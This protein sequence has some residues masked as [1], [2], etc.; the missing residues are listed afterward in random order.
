MNNNGSFEA[1]F[2]SMFV[3][4]EVVI[5][6]VVRFEDLMLESLFMIKKLMMQFVCL[7]RIAQLKFKVLFKILKLMIMNNK[8]VKTYK[9][10]SINFCKI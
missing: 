2:Q 1:R 5:V 9:L 7:N 8:K 6:H 3:P 10:L 4:S